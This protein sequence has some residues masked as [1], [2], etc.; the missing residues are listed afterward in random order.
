[1]GPIRLR[2]R[3]DDEKTGSLAYWLRVCFV[4]PIAQMCLE[5]ASQKRGR[6]P[7]PSSSPSPLSR[8]G[9][10][11]KPFNASD[12]SGLPPATLAGDFSLRLARISDVT[13][14]EAVRLAGLGCALNGPF[15]PAG[16]ETLISLLIAGWSTFDF[17]SRAFEFASCTRFHNPEGHGSLSYAVEGMMSFG[18]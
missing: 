3:L 16:D 11:G 17:A 15:R 7:L 12:S 18:V 4:E 8:E 10:N 2:S 6:V 1:M 14:S 9:P 13:R 5:G